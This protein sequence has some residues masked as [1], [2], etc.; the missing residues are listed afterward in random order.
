M[1]R[2]TIEIPIFALSDKQLVTIVNSLQEVANELEP[3]SGYDPRSRK[4]VEDLLAELD[5]RATTIVPPGAS[6]RDIPSDDA[7][8]FACAF[9]EAFG[10][11]L[12]RA[13]G[14]READ[15]HENAIIEW[16]WTQVVEAYNAG[17]DQAKAD[18]GVFKRGVSGNE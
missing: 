4:C 1:A 12:L 7:E 10:P 15:E 13:F 3:K 6:T 14:E 16:A 5:Q 18:I 11:L 9:D 2:R 17:Y 8:T